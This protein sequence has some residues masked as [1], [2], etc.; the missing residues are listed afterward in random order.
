VAAPRVSWTAPKDPRSVQLFQPTHVGNTPIWKPC[1]AP[2]I[3]A[4]A[5]NPVLTTNR[6]L[7]NVAQ[8]MA[9]CAAG[10][11]WAVGERHPPRVLIGRILGPVVKPKVFKN[12]EPLRRNSPTAKDL[13]VRDDRDLETERERLS[14]GRASAQPLLGRASHLGPEPAP[15]SRRCR[16]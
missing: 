12:D 1:D 9:H 5:R 4:E 11:E 15:E 6:G 10:M 7:M 13:V 8:A 3:P 16:S 2:L 14:H